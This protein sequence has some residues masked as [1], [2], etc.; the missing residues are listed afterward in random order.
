[1]TETH[2]LRPEASVLNLAGRKVLVT[3]G[4]S[5]IGL[6]IARGFQK[7]GSE[8]LISDINAD[9]LTI[10]H[11]EGFHTA[12]ADSSSEEAVRDLIEE[13]Q[14]ALG[15][16]DV[17]VNNAGIAGPT[18][19]I[20]TIETPAWLKTF[21]VNIHS[22][23]YAIKYA[24]PL[25]RR[26]DQASIINLASAAGRLGMAGR[27]PYSASKWAVVGLTKTLAIEL[28]PESIRVNAI[29]P[30][31]VNGPRIQAV[32][33]DKAQM[34][35]TSDEEVAQLYRDQASLQRLAEPEDIGNTAVYLASD[36]AA[37]VHG[38]AVAV[39]GNTEKLY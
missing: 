14:R 36:L 37:H 7:M 21:D 13:T 39:D 26:S 34:L 3:A 10:A 15:G 29:C 12:V 27:S 32:I 11:Q 33:H 35:T 1:M 19:P 4:G 16:L 20:E 8:V 18:G 30:G 2:N 22:Q 17:L 6:A 5:G 31:A 25:L 28:G 9:A 24:L 23:F 38:Q